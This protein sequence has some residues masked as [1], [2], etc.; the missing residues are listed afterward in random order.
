[1]NLEHL[2]TIE[3]ISLDI[4]DE[5]I[6]DLLMN[7]KFLDLALSTINF[8]SIE[9]DQV[10]SIGTDGKTIYFNSS[11]LIE[12]YQTLNKKSLEENIVNN[13]VNFNINR[14]I[15][16]SLLHC[17]F[18]HQNAIIIDGSIIDSI[19]D[20]ACDITTEYIIDDLNNPIFGVKNVKIDGEKT[21]IYLRIKKDL[22]SRFNNSNFIVKNVYYYLLNCDNDKIELYKSLFVVDEHYNWNYQKDNEEEQ[23]IPDNSM[24]KVMQYI[25]VGV[26]IL[27]KLKGTK[28]NELHNQLK[29][30]TS[31]K[32]DYRNFLKRFM[33]FR[34]VLSVDVDSFDPIYYTLGLNIYKNVPLIEYNEVKEEYL[35]EDLVL[36]IDT[37]ASTFG[38]LVEKFISE[39]WAIISQI[40]T[41]KNDSKIR[42]HIIQSDAV[43]QNYKLIETEDEFKEYIHNFELIGGGG[44]DFRPALEYVN[45][46]RENMLFNHLKGVLYFTDGYGEYPKTA[47]DFETV[48]VFCIDDE[49][50][51]EEI[52]VPSWAMKIVLTKGD[53]M[54][55]NY[56]NK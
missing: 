31:T 19:W 4:I 2:E 56:V 29:I 36:I 45:D 38:K 13:K 26:D 39:T 44:T 48:F 22:K 25:Q 54:E 6:K 3:R 47:M 52:S 21:N 23:E 50:I 16:H 33:E 46:M 12:K 18:Y 35:I 14:M 40:I 43:V 17:L 49:C 10:A 15:M 11:F 28:P 20:L 30:M 32:Y 34:E 42:L 51:T 27:E 7:Y 37:S 1:M 8:N 41:S 24:E 9:A 53:I 55:G 5:T